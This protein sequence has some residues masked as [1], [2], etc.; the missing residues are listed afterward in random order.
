MPAK[1]RREV[2]I[3]P[4]ADYDPVL[5]Y[6]NC[7]TAVPI[8]ITA[9]VLD[10]LMR[11][12][13]GDGFIHDVFLV[14]P[15]FSDSA[16][17]PEASIKAI[18]RHEQNIAH[19][20]T[21]FSGKFRVLKA[22]G[23]D[24]LDNFESIGVMPVG[25]VISSADA[26]ALKANECC[27]LKLDSG[28]SVPRVVLAA[29]KI[30]DSVLVR[31]PN[32]YK[33]DGKISPFTAELAFARFLLHDSSLYAVTLLGAAGTGK[34]TMAIHAAVELLLAGEFSSIEIYKSTHQAKGQPP[35]A[36]VPGNASQKFADFRKPVETTLSKVLRDLSPR[37]KACSIGAK[38]PSNGNKG[39]SGGKHEQERSYG[40]L[41]IQILSPAFL[42]GEDFKKKC[43][44]LEEAQNF[45]SG[46]I[47]LAGSRLGSRSR[48]FVVGDQRQVDNPTVDQKSNGLTDMIGRMQG[49]ENYGQVE[50]TTCLRKGA[51]KMFIDAY[52]N[53]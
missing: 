48:L 7:P 31:V 14:H 2:L 3:I 34:S 51:A 52:Y 36:A 11:R 1:D 4:L 13:N 41:P 17:R 44:I 32:P 5:P 53:T 50:L 18:L 21:A 45:T 27:V 20:E 25:E 6:Q 39:K 42:R 9:K 8:N 43:I 16:T 47:L 49:R 22:K 19:D 46:M 37:I 38:P 10:K 26:E 35:I 24:V 23:P 40:G 12:K 33:I 30:Q 29:Y 15:D 28:E